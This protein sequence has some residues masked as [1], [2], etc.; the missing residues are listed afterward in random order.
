MIYHY[1]CPVH[2]G[3]NRHNQ[4]PS[5]NGVNEHNAHHITKQ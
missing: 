3:M 1:N 4:K 2:T 5:G